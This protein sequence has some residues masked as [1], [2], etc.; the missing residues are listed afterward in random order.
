MPVW[1]IVGIIISAVLG[2]MVLI[3]AII[4][5]K[6]RRDREIADLYRLVFEQRVA[7]ILR[8]DS[9]ESVI[10]ELYD[11]G[12]KLDVFSN[13]PDLERVREIGERL[14]NVGGPPL[15]RQLLAEVDSID[16]ERSGVER[17]I[18]KCWDGIGSWLG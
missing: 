16:I 9:Y 15:M 18:E 7:N 2:L 6:E 3:G 13:A 11:L 1:L 10:D 17:R 14:D 12:S 5:A 4:E 8:S